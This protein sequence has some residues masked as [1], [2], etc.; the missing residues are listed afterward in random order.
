VSTFVQSAFDTEF[1]AQEDDAGALLAPQRLLRTT[2]GLMLG[3]YTV[4][5]EARAG[6]FVEYDFSADTGPVAPGVNVVLLAQRTIAPVRWTLLTDFKGYFPTE[7]DSAEDLGFTLQ[8]R[9]EIGVQPLKRLIPG[10]AVGGF[11]D[12]LV[13]Q[14]KVDSN[15][16][17]GMHLLVGASLTYDADLRPPLRL[18]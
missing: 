7:A 8:L 1:T 17:V 13:F 6:I 14:G 12:A 9:A 5:R 11:A 16:R 15:D 3:K 18:R 10:L 4:L 2:G